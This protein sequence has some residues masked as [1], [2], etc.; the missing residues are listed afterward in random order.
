MNFLL[1][2]ICIKNRTCYY[3][4]N[5]IKSKDFDLDNT[6]INEWSNAN[7]LSYEILYKTLIGAKPQ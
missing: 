2:K 6:L 1:N 4:D 3:L 5:I 7:I